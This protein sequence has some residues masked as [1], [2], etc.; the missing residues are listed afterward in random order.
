M[1]QVD[2]DGGARAGEP[3]HCCGPLRRCR[4]LDDQW[5][6]RSTA[7]SGEADDAARCRL[8]GLP[9]AAIAGRYEAIV[10]ALCALALAA[11]CHW[12]SSPGY[13]L[14]AGCGVG[15]VLAALRLADG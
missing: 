11:V 8:G 3:R 1:E 4:P 2:A 12:R 7:E 9:L 15:V 14:V 6:S 5:C 13:P 10:A